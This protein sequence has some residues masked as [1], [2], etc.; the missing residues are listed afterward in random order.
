MRFGRDFHSTPRSRALF[1]DQL[2]AQRINYSRGLLVCGLTLIIILLFLTLSPPVSLI[3]AA[4]PWVTYSSNVYS[5]VLFISS[6]SLSSTNRGPPNIPSSLCLLTQTLP[7]SK[8]IP[9]LISTN[10][11][12]M[13]H[14]STPLPDALLNSGLIYLTTFWILIRHFQLYLFQSESYCL[15]FYASH[16]LVYSFM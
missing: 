9:F 3:R 8:F 2:K 15:P 16:S 13:I 7:L 10:A 5:S 6:L 12:L 1:Y 4:L 11:I 14:R